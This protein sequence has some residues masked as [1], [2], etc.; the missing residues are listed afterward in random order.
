V[1]A[2]AGLGVGMLAANVP[3]AQAATLFCPGGTLEYAPVADVEAY[4]GSETVHG[5]SV[6]QGTT[7]DDTRDAFSGT[8][9]GFIDDA[10]GKGKDLLLFKL[11]SPVIDGTSSSGLKATGIWAGMSGS[12]VYDDQDRLIGAVSYSL[13]P[14]NIPIAGVTPA[15]YMKSIGSSAVSA[16]AKVRVTDSNLKADAAGTRVAGTTLA[17]RTLTQVP[18]VKIAGGAG[19]RENAFTNRT[20]A[21]TP[22]TARS[23][24]FLRSGDFV[25][26]AQQTA[27]V[28]TPLEA[29]GSI[30]VLYTASDLTLGAIGTVTAVCDGKVWAFGHPMDHTGRT[31]LMMANASTALIV[32]DSTG[33]SGSYKQT[34]QIGAPIGTITEDRQVGVRGTIGTPTTVP[35]DLEVT[36]ADGPVASYH[37]DVAVADVTATAVAYLVGQAAID[38]LDQYSTGTGEISWNIGYERA[39]GTTGTV[40]N[41][42]V[43]NS[44]YDFPDEVMTPP[45]DAVWAIT[46]NEF[47]EVAITGVTATLKLVSADS[48]SYKVSGVQVETSPGTWGSLSGARLKPGSTNSVR[49]QYTLRKNDKPHDTVYGAPIPFTLK[50]TAKTSGYFKVA[51]ANTYNEACDVDSRGEIVCTDWN[52]DP[53]EDWTSFD[54]V[55]DT[56]TTQHPYDSV[57]GALKYSLK[58]GS[59]STRFGWT[60]P[61]VVTGSAKAS[62]S[63][64][65]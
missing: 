15:E 24:A 29:G 8:Y 40:T 58:K 51:A 38:Q 54:D 16:L 22:R 31:T 13:S 36:N 63:I 10:L 47:E 53:S 12:P 1:L 65:K 35:I 32:P 61:G 64:K 2:A 57:L 56:L 33:L 6:T 9:I 44:A 45:A 55:L 26:A 18:T 27:A 41:R 25:A 60:G 21:R 20:L 50:T 42:Q 3:A 7:V 23:A 52:F 28:S 19:S 34:S 11:S 37:T 46:Q 43:I 4:T 49:A 62:F 14:D 5:L 39:D 30:A 59:T 17:G 48:L